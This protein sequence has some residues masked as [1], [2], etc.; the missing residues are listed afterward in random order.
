MIEFETVH[1]WAEVFNRRESVYQFVAVANLPPGYYRD[2]LLEIVENP[3]VRVPIVAKAGA[4]GDWA[5]YIGWPPSVTDI[6]P[7]IR[8]VDL[9]SV[10][11]CTSHLGHPEGALRN[12]DKLSEAEATALFPDM[13]AWSTMGYRE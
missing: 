12:G 11:Y 3:I 6:K 1:S 7:E 9:R 5:A 10:D 8:A 2:C 4:I 13:A